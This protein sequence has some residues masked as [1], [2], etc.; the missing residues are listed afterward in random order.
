MGVCSIVVFVVRLD[1]FLLGARVILGEDVH[2]HGG[3]GLI[4]VLG[5][6]QQVKITAKDIDL[7]NVITPFGRP[8]KR[9]ICLYVCCILLYEFFI[10][11][12]GTAVA[13]V[14][15]MPLAII[16]RQPPICIRE[17]D[18]SKRVQPNTMTA[19]GSQ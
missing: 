6:T 12:L 16:R 4:I 9:L 11:L 3:N 14:A 7:G 5:Q 13:M 10:L 15:K 8:C 1:A 2:P 18:S 19:M 17:S